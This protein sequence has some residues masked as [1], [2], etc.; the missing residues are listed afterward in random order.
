MFEFFDYR[1]NTLVHKLAGG[2]KEN[3]GK[4]YWWLLLKYLQPVIKEVLVER[5]ILHMVHSSIAP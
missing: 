4:T 5:H 3:S 1:P 2:I